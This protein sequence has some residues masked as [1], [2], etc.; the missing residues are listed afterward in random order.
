MIT[1]KK[2]LIPIS[3]LLVLFLLDGLISSYFH[4][5]LYTRLGFIAPRLTIVG[6]MLYG[7]HLSGRHL[8]ILTIIVGFLYDSFY[9]GFLGIYMGACCLMVYLVY[10]L[11]IYLKPNLAVFAIIGIL[12]LTLMELFVFSVYHAISLTMVSYDY[13]FANHLG[14]TLMFNGIILLLSYKGIEWVLTDFYEAKD[15]LE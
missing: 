11:R 12:M 6:L 4:S 9:T 8:F 3:L 7:L 13:F 5:T 1:W 10:Q 15:V 2:E 14:G